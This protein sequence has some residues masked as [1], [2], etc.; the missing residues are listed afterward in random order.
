M[1]ILIA[2]VSLALLFFVSAGG[3]S[4]ENPERKNDYVPTSPP[5]PPKVKDDT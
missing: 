4:N 3:E 2:I 5:N 1:I